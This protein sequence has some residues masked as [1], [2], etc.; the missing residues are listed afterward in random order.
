MDR[1][2]PFGD[3][4]RLNLKALV[5][6]HNQI[7]VLGHH[8]ADPDAVCSMIA[9]SNLYQELN[10]R[11]QVVMACD[12]VSRLA[13]QVIDSFDSSA[14][15]LEE[16]TEDYPFV[17]LIDTNSRFQLGVGMK[18]VLLHP[19]T[20][21]VIDHHEPNPEIAFLAAHVIADSDR[22][23]TCEI[24]YE[25]YEQN[26]LDISEKTA[27]L[28]LTGMLFDTRRFLYADK[29][30]LSI[31]LKL[32]DAGA[33]YERCVNSL[34]IQQDRSERIA[35]L[36]AARRL[37]IHQ[38]EEWIVVTAKVSAFE[39]SACRGLLDLGADV[40][41]VGGQPSKDVVRLSSRST[42][43]FHVETGINLGKDVMEHLGETIGGEGGG[44]PNAAG[45][46]GK[47]NR[48]KALEQAV[49]LLRSAIARC[50]GTEEAS[51]TR[52]S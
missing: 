50:K 48:T 52:G 30:A 9:F 39:A 49:E 1:K 37:E 10:P 33:D 7:L 28:L 5:S 12:D 21:L 2:T 29:R 51:D 43:R 40:A 3:E 15:I 19:P 27:N 36:K 34:R 47:R 31:A 38:I 17:V 13:R 25:L 24:I 42:H 23:S 46:N 26:G 6:E 41:I 4:I 16:V 22:S 44:H 45:A 14:K 32:L 11:G 18:D 8:N 35:R 20:T